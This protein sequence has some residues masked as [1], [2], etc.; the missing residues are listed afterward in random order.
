MELNGTYQ[1]LGCDDCL[2]ANKF[3]ENIAGSNI[4]E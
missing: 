4:W 3:F 1:L 2:I